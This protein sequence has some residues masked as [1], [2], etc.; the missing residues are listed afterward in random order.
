MLSN[1]LRASRS[2]TR[3]QQLARFWPRCSYAA[4]ASHG[5]PPAAPQDMHAAKQEL[6]RSIKQRLRSLTPDAMQQQSERAAR[7]GSELAA[8]AP[9]RHL[10]HTRAQAGR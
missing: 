3:R 7:R 5:E 10:A 9:C 8:P 6:R 2:S 1:A 4:M